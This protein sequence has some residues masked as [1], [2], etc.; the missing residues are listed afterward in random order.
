MGQYDAEPGHVVGG[1]PVLQRGGERRRFL[2][3]PP[4]GPPRRE[5]P[6]PPLPRQGVQGL[7]VG[8]GE[9]PGFGGGLRP[10]LRNPAAGGFQDLL[11]TLLSEGRLALAQVETIAQRGA[12]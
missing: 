10:K 8:D 7:A 4:P 2:H 1:H 6:L 5:A 12:R 3:L 9:Q 11:R